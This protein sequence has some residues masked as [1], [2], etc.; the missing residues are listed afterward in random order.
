MKPPKQAVE[1]TPTAESALDGAPS[2][3]TDSADQHTS[4]ES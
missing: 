3:N 2:A 4:A 1:N